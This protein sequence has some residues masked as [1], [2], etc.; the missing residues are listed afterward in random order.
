M[1]PSIHRPQHFFVYMPC[2]DTENVLP[3]ND[4]VIGCQRVKADIDGKAR[5]VVVFT[6]IPISEF[7]QAAWAKKSAA[8]A[9]EQMGVLFK[10]TGVS[11]KNLDNALQALK[12]RPDGLN[13]MD[14]LSTRDFEDSAVARLG[15]PMIGSLHD[16][17]ENI[18]SAENTYKE[19]LKKAFEADAIADNPRLANE[20]ADVGEL[21]RTEKP[22]ESDVALRIIK[23]NIKVPSSLLNNRGV[24]DE[25]KPKKI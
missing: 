6:R 1:N 2:A 22:K 13:S 5:S 25:G 17:S 9:I 12:H 14:A 24:M 3:T 7:N 19:G 11:K 16:L 18:P 10:I 20:D 23:K 4:S 21:S 8:E 15:M